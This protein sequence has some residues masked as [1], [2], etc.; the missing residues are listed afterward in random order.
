MVHQVGIGWRSKI[1]VI[2]HGFV[3]GLSSEQHRMG[4]GGNPMPLLLKAAC[5]ATASMWV[6]ASSCCGSCHDDM[7]IGALEGKGTPSSSQGHCLRDIAYH[8]RSLPWD[9]DPSVAC[10]ARVQH[11]VHMGIDAPEVHDRQGSLLN[12]C[13]AQVCHAHCP[14]SRL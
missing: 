10:L 9:A 2:G 14:G 4:H 8:A 13:K 11:G 3:A 6:A 12:K 1:S 5:H 7:G